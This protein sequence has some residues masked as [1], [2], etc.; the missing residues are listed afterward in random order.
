M[1]QHFDLKFEV[2]DAKMPLNATTFYAKIHNLRCQ[3]LLN[4]I[5]FLISGVGAS[6]NRS[7]CHVTFIVHGTLTAKYQFLRNEV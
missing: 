6:L 5:C 1:P 2:F 3:M 7:E 4:A